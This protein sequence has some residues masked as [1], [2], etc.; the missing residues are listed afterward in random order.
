MGKRLEACRSMGVTFDAQGVP[1]RQDAHWYFRNDHLRALRFPFPTS[2]A[3]ALAKDD[4]EYVSSVPQTAGDV[5]KPGKE[6][7]VFSAEPRPCLLPSPIGN[8][9]SGAIAIQR[10]ERDYSGIASGW[11]FADRD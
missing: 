7:R 9:T 6:I 4:F 1:I 8:A 10:G 5:G 3:F 11:E 2:I